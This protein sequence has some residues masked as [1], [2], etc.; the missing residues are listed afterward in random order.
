MLNILTDG[1]Y[2]KKSMMKLLSFELNI[3][4]IKL[5]TI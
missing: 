1:I 5:L 3:G 4:N 2:F